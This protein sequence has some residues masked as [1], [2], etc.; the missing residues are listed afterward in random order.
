MALY[1]KTEEDF[2]PTV[3]SAGG[4]NLI[5]NWDEE[6][7]AFQRSSE[8]LS[9]ILTT[10]EQDEKK[11]QEKLQTQ[12]DTYK[13]LR[14][15]GYDT[16]S[17]YEATMRGQAPSSLPG[18]TASDRKTQAEADK[19]KAETDKLNAETQSITGSSAM[20]DEQL[21][22]K[23]LMR[24]GGKVIRDPSYKRTLTTKERSDKLQDEVDKKE[25]TTMASNLPRLDQAFESVSQL[26]NLFY[27][28]VNPVSVNE[29][30]PLALKIPKGLYARVSGPFKVT[31]AASGLNPK[32]KI[33]L[34]NRK[35]FSGLIAKGGFGEAGMLTNQDIERIKAILPDASATKEEADLAFQEVESIL[36]AARK[37]YEQKKKSYLNRT[38]IVD[39]EQPTTTD[40]DDFSSLWS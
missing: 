3:Q 19:I 20:T 11:K 15:A 5:I 16:K 36:S 12:F 6:P 14:E 4:G 2:K 18:E 25:L 35:A 9:T 1:S 28:A 22:S 33:Y 13:T 32:L 27:N 30:D 31:D 39:D 24:V 40:E 17:A 10:I 7:N 37:R 21:S 29:K 38:N 23:G 26:K 8:V 34:N